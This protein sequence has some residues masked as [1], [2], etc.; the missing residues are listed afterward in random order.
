MKVSLHFIIDSALEF[1]YASSMWDL[2]WIIS[3]G[4]DFLYLVIFF[5]LPVIIVRCL[6]TCL[7]TPSPVAE[8]M[9]LFAATP[10]RPEA[11]NIIITILIALSTFRDI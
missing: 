9:L 5:L 6:L 1:L 2:W 7:S 3:T 10:R 11:I 8:E 4:T